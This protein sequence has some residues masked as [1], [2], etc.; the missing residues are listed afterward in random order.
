[1]I[2][3]LALIKHEILHVITFFRNVNVLHA[4]KECEDALFKVVFNGCVVAAFRLKNQLYKHK[5]KTY[6]GK[7]QGMNSNNSGKR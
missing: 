6:G 3:S 4:Y 7:I 2:Q 5:D 1:M